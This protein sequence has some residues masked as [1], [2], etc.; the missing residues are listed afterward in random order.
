MHAVDAAGRGWS[1]D[2]SG[3]QLSEWER[4]EWTYHAKGDVNRS[5]QNRARTKYAPQKK[6]NLAL[7]QLWRA[8]R[9][10]PLWLD[11]PQFAFCESRHGIIVFY[12]DCVAR[13]AERAAG[14]GR[15][16]TKLCAPVGRS[17][18]AREGHHEGN[19]R[20]SGRDALIDFLR[21]R[22]LSNCKFLSDHG[23]CSIKM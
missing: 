3:V 11:E 19:S 8:T 10:L 16:S 5:E 4:D 20:T 13:R 23:G 15:P 2:H 22:I 18:A 17:G 6:R 1:T 12:D 9:A 21:L 7:P 14:G